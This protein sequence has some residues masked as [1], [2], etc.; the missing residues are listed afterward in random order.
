[1]READGPTSP[2]V[3]AAAGG[4]RANATISG[5]LGWSV[6]SRPTIRRPSTGGFPGTSGRFVLQAGRSGETERWRESS[7]PGD[8]ADVRCAAPKF[9]AQLAFA[10]FSSSGEF[11]YIPDMV[12]TQQR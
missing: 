5:A 4:F 11:T 10:S 7:P 6:S 3:P 9:R 12:S 1:M 8:H 2:G